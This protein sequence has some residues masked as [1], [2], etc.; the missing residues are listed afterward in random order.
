MNVLTHCRLVLQEELAWNCLRL[1]GLSSPNYKN[2]RNVTKFNYLSIKNA[3]CSARIECFTTDFLYLVSHRGDPGSMP[4][5]PRGICGWQSV[6]GTSFSP[7]TSG[8]PCQYHSTKVRNF[9][10]F[11]CHPCYI[12]ATG[13]IV[14]SNRDTPRYCAT[15]HRK[16]LRYSEGSAT[17]K[18]CIVW[19]FCSQTFVGTKLGWRRYIVVWRYLL[20][21][22]GVKFPP[23]ISK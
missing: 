13:I 9:I 23:N 11:I 22:T 3:L 1:Q 19:N 17:R 10:P 6:T 21:V 12:L 2:L 16:L 14:K 4:T 5:N 15:V 20:L 18:Y 8:F 7:S